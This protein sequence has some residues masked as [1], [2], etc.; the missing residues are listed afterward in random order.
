[1]SLLWDGKKF[2][3]LDRQ[4]T[5]RPGLDIIHF[6]LKDFFVDANIITQKEDHFDRRVRENFHK[7][8]EKMGT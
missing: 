3:V 8:N 4:S 5:A 6:N 2:G 7:A 1:L